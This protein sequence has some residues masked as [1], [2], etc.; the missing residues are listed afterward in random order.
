MQKTTPWQT[1][2]GAWIAVS[3]CAALSAAVAG[4]LAARVLLSQ[5]T[6]TPIPSVP[7]ETAN[8]YQQEFTK[9]IDENWRKDLLRSLDDQL[10]NMKDLERNANQSKD[11]SL[12]S[13][14]QNFRSSIDG[15]KSCIQNASTQEALQACNDAMQGTWDTSSKLWTR[16]DL[17]NRQREIT[18]M[19]RQI[20]D[21]EREKS[22]VSKAK[23]ILEQYRAALG[24]VLSLLQSGADNRDVQDAMQNTA[25][26]L[27][28]EFYNAI[29]AARRQ[30]EAARF[31][32][33]QLK[34][35]ERQIKDVE[36]GKGDTTKLREIVERVKTALGAAEQLLLGGVADS[37]DVDDAFRAIYDTEREFQ[38]LQSAANR[39]Q[40][41]KDH[42][43]ELKD[44]ERQVRDAEKRGGANAAE[45]RRLFEEYQAQ[46]ANARKLLEGGT[47]PEDINDAFQAIYE[48]D[49]P[50]Q[51][52]HA[53]AN[54]ANRGRELK[55]REKDIKNMER[56]LRR[57]EKQK[58]ADTQELRQAFEEYRSQLAELKRLVESGTDPENINEGF[59]ALYE[60]GSA[61]QR[62]WNI[63]NAM[64]QAQ[65]MQRWTK[66]GG[67][68]SNMEQDLKRLKRDKVDTS[69]LQ[70]LI[71]QIKAEIQ[72]MQGMALEDQQDAREEVQGLQNDF[73]NTVNALNMKGE[74]R[75]W[76]R[77]GGHIAKME[78]IVKAL[79]KKGKDASVAE[80]VLQQIRAVVA[81]LEQSAD[82]DTLE[83]GRYE[84]DNLRRQFEEA[85][86]PFMKKKTKGFPFP[87][88][89]R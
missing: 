54:I 34:N 2:F 88:K 17:V 8:E 36:R 21:A 56:D 71:D 31:R 40:E 30:G 82:R 43:R 51:K 64:N 63:N 20:K 80:S 7:Q 10:R 83:E 19:E 26:P 22:D 70:S 84:L 23:G 1:T 16:S 69:A 59:Q 6:T 48:Q 89:G 12:L 72:A 57:A 4:N 55:D 29:N 25:Q 87:M 18:D 27:Q 77:K 11:Q 62:F 58:G 85:I 76:T 41:L 75:Q 15:H 38:D 61:S 33:E 67:E 32:N 86:L 81:D 37:R 52:F 46:L 74:L 3:A 24:N 65:E 68:I 39:G 66:K 28:Q 45:L 47:A 9:S 13:E 49:S 53:L 73:W 44:M 35:M 42:E 14:I 79:Q 78:K 5:E 60:E 50:Q